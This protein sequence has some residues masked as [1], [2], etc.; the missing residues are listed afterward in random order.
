MERD[1][2]IGTG[3][4][5]I[6]AKIR[7]AKTLKQ[8]EADFLTEDDKLLREVIHE[9]RNKYIDYICKALQLA[10][11]RKGGLVAGYCHAGQADGM[12]LTRATF[13][14]MIKFQ[15]LTD[16]LKEL[17]EE[18]AA[19][20]D[21]VIPKEDGPDK[22]A[23]LLLILDDFEKNEQVLSCWSNATKMRRWLITK[24]QSIAEKLEFSDD[25]EQVEVATLQQIIQKVVEKAE[26]LSVLELPSA[27]FKADEEEKESEL[28]L[29]KKTSL[30][31]QLSKPAEAQTEPVL[32]LK[33]NPNQ[34]SN[35]R[36]ELLGAASTTS[37]LACL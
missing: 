11:K 24:K 34:L 2:E 29:E 26:F 17:I 9:G 20:D 10:L 31:R 12:R 36:A 28:P 32:D 30:M 25:K 3:N 22:D 7:E 5:E 4:D 15:R 37:V 18:T 35:E 19:S 21:F 23:A 1:A 33:K 27:A 16:T 6:I 13:A 8:N 14:V